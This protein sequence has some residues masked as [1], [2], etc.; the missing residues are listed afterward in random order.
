VPLS[1]LSFPPPQPVLFSVPV[2][3]PPLITFLANARANSSYVNATSVVRFSIADY[4]AAANGSASN[5]FSQLNAAQRALFSL[6]A[7][8]DS[9][10]RVGLLAT[11]MVPKEGVT[12]QHSA[13][14]FYERCKP[15]TC[16]F[17]RIE[18]RDGPSIAL[19]A[20]G[21]FG[22]NGAAIVAILSTL[23]A[24]LAF[25]GRRMDKLL[26]PQGSAAEE[27]QEKAPSS[28]SEGQVLAI[29]AQEA[30]LMSSS[31]GASLPSPL[32]AAE[33]GGKDS[34][35]TNPVFRVG[36]GSAGSSAAQAAP[37]AGPSSFEMAPIVDWGSS[38]Q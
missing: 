31:S 6:V 25:F 29:E 17:T 32:A 2:K 20:I 28:S 19:D 8:G 38:R 16:T 12:F 3:C 30:A 15:A 27:A 24:W 36:S 35:A 26:Q 22:G 18:A 33:R 21:T 14:K 34:V 7:R 4:L 1:N 11:V 37:A 13:E 23:V 10:E 5:V 9:A